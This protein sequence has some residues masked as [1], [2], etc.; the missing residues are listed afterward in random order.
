MRSRPVSILVV[1][2]L[3]AIPAR[4]WAQT[5]RNASSA[6]LQQQLN[7]WYAR[8]SRSAPGTWGIAVASQDGQLLWGVQPTRAMIP[9]S[10]VKLF[11][12]GYARSVLGG[13]AR[14][15]TRVVGVGHV[16]PATGTWLGTWSLEL[17]GDPTL[18]R[19]VRGGPTLSDLARQLHEAGIR[20]FIGPLHV[21]SASGPAGASYPDV[22]ENRHKGR[23]FAP[24]IGALTLN[25]NV[26]SFAIAPS[27]KAGQKPVVVAE[28][29][30]GIGELVE[31]RAKTVAGRTSRLRYQAAPG[32]RYIVSGTIGTRARTRWFTSTA[33]DPKVLLEASWARALRL[34]GI[35]WQRASGLAAPVSAASPTVLAEVRSETFDSIAS[36][37][38][39]RSLNIGA[40]LL[41]RWAAGDD[42]PAGR[43]TAHVQEITGDY[44]SVKLVDGSGLSRDDRASPLALV[45]YLVKFP[46][47]PGGRGFPM[48]LPTNGSG[49]LRKLGR[50]LPG[51]GV[52]RAK[53]GTLGDVATLAGYLG[54][55]DGVL[56]ISLMY[57]GP[58]VYS[59]RQEQW[60]LFRL[61]GAEGVI[62]PQDSLGV[63]AGQL[64]GDNRE[65]PGP[66]EP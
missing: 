40:E 2:A 17:N 12:T 8:A 66:R 59:A 15:H 63:E 45:S 39:R 28:S 62:L 3:A 44:A 54:R 60:R 14:R 34:A 13:E 50:G 4:A 25:E 7:G 31:V 56:V 22:W 37:V 30:S 29:P 26:L 48:L 53:T 10:T 24:L 18:E 41:L 20:R 47:S 46:L 16:D 11:T 58:R 35:E 19:P 27:S 55:A 21:A 32:G 1:L 6:S 42:N 57:N 64:G 49:T 5:A 52:V 9:A 36:E 61:L 65:P 38:N 23:L 51:P 33:K 43:L